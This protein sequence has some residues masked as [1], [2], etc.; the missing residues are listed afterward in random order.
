[1]QAFAQAW[2]H[3]QDEFSFLAACDTTVCERTGVCERALA[4]LTG[5]SLGTTVNRSMATTHQ[6]RPT[7]NTQPD[8]TCVTAR[9]FP[10]Y[11]NTW[12]CGMSLTHGLSVTPVSDGHSRRS[13]DRRL[14]SLVL[15]LTAASL[16]AVDSC[17]EL[18]T[19]AC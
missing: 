15:C 7:V 1:M 11:K 16:L 14:V 17:A 10:T 2:K 6:Q 3:S 13:F 8:I 12:S 19:T 5:N 9:Q 4:C 18:D